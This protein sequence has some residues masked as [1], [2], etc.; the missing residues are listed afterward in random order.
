MHRLAA[1]TVVVTGASRGMGEA[2]AR[3]FVAEGARVLLTDVLDEQGRAAAAELGDAAAY[4]HHDVTDEASW[5]AVLDEVGRRFGP[6]DVLV[7]NAGILHVAPL[8]ATD[9][10]DLQRVLSVNLVGPFLGMKVL[11]GAMAEVGRGS[12]VNVSS[13]G[14]MIGMSMISAYVASKWALRGMTKSAA[15]ELGHRGVRVNS[16]HPG[17]VATAMAGGAESVLSEPPAPGAPEPDPQLG[18]LD[19]RSA[20]QPIPRIGRPVEIARLALFLA[21]DESSYCTGME[22]VAD[23]GDTA[24]HDLSASF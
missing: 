13:T 12:I 5:H 20:H 8:L 9:V 11:G 1:K 14:G 6:P 4:L 3:L 23:G 21:S 7:N 2:Q 24:G 18:A 10:A 22:F 16:L 17:G 15:I 19:A